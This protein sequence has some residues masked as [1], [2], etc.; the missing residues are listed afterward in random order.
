MSIKEENQSRRLWDPYDVSLP[1]VAGVLSSF[2]QLSS[3]NKVA[4]APYIIDGSKSTASASDAVAPNSMPEALLH[5][6]PENGYYTPSRRRSCKH[7][8]IQPNRATMDC[9]KEVLLQGLADGCILF[10]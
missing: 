2:N 3:S 9:T 8:P 1:T 4:A 10:K 7:I 6:L 5:P